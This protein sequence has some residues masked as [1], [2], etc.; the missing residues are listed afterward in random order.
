MELQTATTDAANVTLTVNNTICTTYGLNCTYG[1]V[2]G[3]A[4]LS[5]TG[6]Q[7]IAI[8][9]KVIAVY[10]VVTMNWHF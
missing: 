6:N 7:S 9:Q 1:I 2:S 8:Y 5:I 4:A 10:L 3:R